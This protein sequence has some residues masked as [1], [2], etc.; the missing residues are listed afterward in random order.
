ML[1]RP[2]SSRSAGIP[3]YRLRSS[4][5]PSRE[6]PHTQW[7]P[8]I[9]GDTRSPLFQQLGHLRTLETATGTD[10]QNYV[11]LRKQLKEEAKVKRGAKRKKG[12]DPRLARWELT[13]GIEIHAQLNTESKLFSSKVTHPLTFSGLTLARST[14]LSQRCSQF[15]RLPLRSCIPR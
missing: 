5:W 12:E 1:L 9:R 13:V 6:L 4:R 11:P 15:Q 10:P 3:W 7:R 8:S 2:C 14:D